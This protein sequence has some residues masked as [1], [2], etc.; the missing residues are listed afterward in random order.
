MIFSVRLDALEAAVESSDEMTPEQ[1]EDYLVRCSRVIA[2]L[3]A[4]LP[5]PTPAP[6]DGE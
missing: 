3:Y 1:A 2:N 6:T 4:A 5:D